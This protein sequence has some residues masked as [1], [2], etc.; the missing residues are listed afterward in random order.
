M[1]WLR[2]PLRSSYRH[3]GCEMAALDSAQF[4]YGLVVIVNILQSEVFLCRV[5]HRWVGWAYVHPDG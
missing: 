4:S 1:T 2:F 5:D 3:L